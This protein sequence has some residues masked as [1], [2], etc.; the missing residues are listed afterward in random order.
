M[1]QNNKET[2]QP[3]NEDANVREIYEEY[4][5]LT[6]SLWNVRSSLTS[7]DQHRPVPEKSRQKSVRLLSH[8]SA[9]RKKTLVPFIVVPSRLTGT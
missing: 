4:N 7:G 5:E 9:T 1:R 2:A 3:V 8:S 6:Q